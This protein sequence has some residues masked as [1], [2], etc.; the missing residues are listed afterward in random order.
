MGMDFVDIMMRLE[1]SFDI[2]L[3]NEDFQEPPEPGS[4]TPRLR[5]TVGDLYEIVREKRS[6]DTP[7]RASA[8][9]EDKA[10]KEVHQGLA[11]VLDV[12]HEQI[13]RDGSLEELIAE[14]VRNRLWRRLKRQLR[15]K[16]PSL[17]PRH[18]WYL[19]AS[20]SSAFVTASIAFSAL[21]LTEPHD[22][23]SMAS[24]VVGLVICTA[25]SIAIS[26]V[27]VEVLV[28]LPV[29]PFVEFPQGLQTVGDLAQSILALNRTHF[30][31]LCGSDPDD[32]IWESLRFIIADVLAVDPDQ[33]TKD[34]DLIRDLGAD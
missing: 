33:V 6:R 4:K 24:F 30:V 32:D 17:K 23:E 16:L 26:Q 3:E 10:L 34:A 22:S 27:F 1:E 12:P 15:M 14:P 18:K 29:W 11:A 25:I 21:L 28:T 19:V 31:E 7:R 9:L 2:R 20:W 5:T 13:E 8:S